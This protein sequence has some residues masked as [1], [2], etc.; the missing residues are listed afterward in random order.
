MS[1]RNRLRRAVAREQA[2]AAEQLLAEIERQ[3]LPRAPV[4]AAYGQ[5]PALQ[6]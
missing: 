3:G 1:A 4:A 5:R 6:R 2:R